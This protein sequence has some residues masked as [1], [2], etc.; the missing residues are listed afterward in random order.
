MELGGKIKIT[1]AEHT[2]F[3]Y[4]KI[5]LGMTESI[6]HLIEIIIAG[7][8]QTSTYASYYI[9]SFSH[10]NCPVSWY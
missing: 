8:Y 10:H 5:Y 3:A 6:I 7:I 4:F 9:K 1:I 2:Y